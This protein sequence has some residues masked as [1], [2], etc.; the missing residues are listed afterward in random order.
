MIQHAPQ[1]VGIH[2]MLGIWTYRSSNFLTL[3]AVR[4]GC[5]NLVRP[6]TKTRLAEDVIVLFDLIL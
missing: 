6:G 4:G 3:G 5:R 1:I 2:F